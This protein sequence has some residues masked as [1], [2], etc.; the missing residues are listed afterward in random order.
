MARA[1][2]GVLVV[3]VVH[4]IWAYGVLSLWAEDSDGP[5]TAQPRAG[6]PSRAPRAH[7]FAGGLDGLADAVAE[8]AG[9]AADLARKAIEDELTLWLPSTAGGPLA[10]PAL[11]R[12]PGTEPVRPPGRPAR[13]ALAAWRLPALTFEPDTALDLL[14]VLGGPGARSSRAVTGG[15]V[16]YL[17]AVARLAGALPALVTSAGGPEAGY[18]A[19]W[20]PVLSGADAQRARDLA[21]AMPPLCR[22]SDPDGTPSA[23]V[24]TDALEVLADVAARARLARDH[25]FGLVAAGPGRRPARIPVAERWAAALTGADAQVPVAT[26]EDEAEAAEL[27]AGLEAWRASAQVPVGPVRTCFRLIEPPAEVQE[28]FSEGGQGGQEPPPGWP[29]EAS[30]G[31]QGGQEEPPGWPGEASAGG[32]GVQEPPPGAPVPPPGAPVPPPGAPVP[33]PGAPVPPPGAPVPPRA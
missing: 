25:G 10:S 26:A 29:G 32:Q 4:G 15:S 9:L 14:A 31:G 27:A 1:V 12:E 13:P 22:A 23:R 21:A 24:L 7:P 18:E 11:I 16:L 6:R 5:A 8:L 19:R 17:A 2:A 30:T 20:R 3:L 33:P 28:E